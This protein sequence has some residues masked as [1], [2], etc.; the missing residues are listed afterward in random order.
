VVNNTQV[1]PVEY[2]LSKE[3]QGVIF[4]FS[5]VALCRALSRPFNYLWVKFIYKKIKKWSEK[6][7]FDHNKHYKEEELESKR[8]SIAVLFNRIENKN[9]R[10]P[11]IKGIEAIINEGAE[12][13]QKR[14]LESIKKQAEFHL[15]NLASS[16]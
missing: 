1:L 13:Y 14:H 5:A 9:L 15:K 11:D 7:D 10:Q 6:S 12:L 4:W 3:W 16:A 2:K 8:E